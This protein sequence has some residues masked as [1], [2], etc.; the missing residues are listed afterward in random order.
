MPRDEK[1]DRLSA[2]LVYQSTDDYIVAQSV[3][4]LVNNLTPLILSW[5]TLLF[6]LLSFTLGQLMNEA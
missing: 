4:S 1:S 3:L 2:Q 5:A 6:H